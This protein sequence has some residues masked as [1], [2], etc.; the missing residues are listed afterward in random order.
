MK[1]LLSPLA[2]V[3]SLSAIVCASVSAETLIKDGGVE[4]SDKEFAVIFESMPPPVKERAANDVADRLEV[5]NGLL[6]PRKLAAMADEID[7]EDDD[8]WALQFA[9]IAAK[10]EFMYRKLQES[11]VEPDFE[12]LARERYRVNPKKYGLVPEVRSSSHILF[13]SPPGLDRT[14][15]RKQAAEVLAELRAG[16]SFEEAVAQYSGDPGSK[17]RDGSLGRFIRFGDPGITPPYSQALFEIENIGEYSEPTDS[18]F[19]I[20]IIRL[21]GIK[22]SSIATYEQVKEAILTEIRREFT[23]MSNT[24]IRARF[25]VSDDLYIDG[26]A[27]EALFAPY[28]TRP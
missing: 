16:A 2:L 3:F 20:H 17:A 5:I 14:E 21:D 6:I 19:G 15:V 12:P 25:N 9:L 7:P 11:I 28:R 18:Q 13:Q 4:I 27:M 8:Y 1:N 10:Q 24:E 22:E 26:P 23:A